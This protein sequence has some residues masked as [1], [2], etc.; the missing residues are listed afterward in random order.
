VD[1]LT[2]LS[3]AL[4]PIATAAIAAWGAIRVERERTRKVEA[5]RVHTAPRISLASVV[6]GRPR[7]LVV[8]DDFASA[9]GARRL[10][11][12]LGCEVDVAHTAEEARALQ[13]SGLTW[14]VAVGDHLLIDGDGSA[15]LGELQE[16]QR[17][18]TVLYTGADLA[19]RPAGVDVM[20][21]KPRAAEMVEAVKRLVG[22][23]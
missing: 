19:A 6:P 3:H 16:G 9:R 5:G 4:P 17:L 23:E 21:E 15:L 11:S 20:V 13:A 10:L 8:E 1:L 18:A 22:V 12:E 14:R 2:A 7:V